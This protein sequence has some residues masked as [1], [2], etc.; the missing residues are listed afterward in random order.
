[1]HR[2]SFQIEIKNECLKRWELGRLAA[3]WIEYSLFCSGNMICSFCIIILVNP[4]Y[5]WSPNTNDP[6]NIVENQARVTMEP[7]ISSINPINYNY[8][9]LK[10]HTILITSNGCRLDSGGWRNMNIISYQQRKSHSGDKTFLRPS[11]L[12]NGISYAGK[13]IY[14]Y[15]IR[16]QDCSV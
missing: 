2:K 6:W 15:W 16:S 4:L 3:F 13:M 10:K 11:C 12:H 14:L 7:R 8:V 9:R 1:M 5:Q